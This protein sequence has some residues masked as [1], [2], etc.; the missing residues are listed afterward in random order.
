MSDFA[1]VLCGVPQGS[2][3]APM[4]FCLH[5]IPLGATLRH[6]NIGYHIYGDDTQLISFK[7]KD[8]FE[9]LTKLN[10]CMSDI[11]VWMIK[12]KI[13]DPKTEFIIFRSPLLKQNLSNLSIG[14]GYIQVTPSSKVR[15]ATA[16]LIHALITT[17]FDFWNNI[18]H[19]LPNNK[20]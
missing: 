1:S 3:L 4:Q 5:L 9:S 17:C 12:N 7:C 13:N 10:M 2:V 18:L 20:I 8:P 11:R 15:D 19:K 6:H 16:Q 14:V